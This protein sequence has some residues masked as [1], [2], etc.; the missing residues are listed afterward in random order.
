MKY[1]FLLIIFCLNSAF[2]QDKKTK[3][4]LLFKP[5]FRIH[6]IIPSHLGDNYLSKANEPNIGLGINLYILEC[7]HF[8]FGLGYNH[9]YHTITDVSKAGNIESSLYKS[10]FGQLG[11]NVK[12]SK[13]LNIQPYLG[14]GSVR[15]KFK[16]GSRSFGYQTGNDFRIGSNFDYKIDETYSAF[17]GVGYVLSSYDINT[18]PEYISFYNHSKMIQINIGIKIN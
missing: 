6:A 15:L 9:I 18:S 1:Y 14:F 12:L 17:L 11:Y 16:T 8:T 10:F 13:E 3:S 4:T 5:E 2:G 7:N